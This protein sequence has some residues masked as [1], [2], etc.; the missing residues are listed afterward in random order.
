MK[1][2]IGIVIEMEKTPHGLWASACTTTSAS[3][4]SRIVMIVMIPMIAAAPPTEPSSSR[5]ICPSERPRRR[6]DT[7][8]TR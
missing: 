2:A 7:H 3:T 1:S 6:V 8:N 4:A 5:T